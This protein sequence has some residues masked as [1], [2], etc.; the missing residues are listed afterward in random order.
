LKVLVIGQ[1]SIGVRH[2]RV[3]R[4]LGAR[5]GV[6]TKRADIEP[7]ALR[8]DTIDAARTFAPDVVVIA[9][10]T[11]RHKEALAMVASAL[12]PARVLVEKPVFARDEAPPPG[13]PSTTWVGYCMRFHPALQA[14][15]DHVRGRTLYAVHATVGQH[16]AQWRPGTDYRS[17]YSARAGEGGALRDLSHELDLVYLVAGRHKMVAAL[18]GH[19]SDLETQSEDCAS[20]LMETERCPHVTVHM[21]TIDRVPRRTLVVHAQGTTA[22]ADMVRNIVRIDGEERSVDVE[23]DTIYAKQLAAVADRDARWLCTIDDARQTLRLIS[24]AEMSARTKTFVRSGEA[25]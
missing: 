13:T 16:L 22:E 4:A 12:P 21:D 19:V 18:S 11:G 6:V 15:V 3:A 24:A 5:I 2:A 9:N 20:L 14:V 8:F 7:G 1:G 10:E 25:T 23:R 17:S